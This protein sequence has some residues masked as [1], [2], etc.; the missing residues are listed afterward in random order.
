[1]N[2]IFEGQRS[3]KKSVSAGKSIKEYIGDPFKI[4]EDSYFYQ[5]SVCFTGTCKW[6][7]RDKLLQ[8]SADI[9]GFP[10]KGVNKSTCKFW[11]LVSKIT[12]ASVRM[13]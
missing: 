1:M 5:K 4:D 8:C 7:S 6:A 12:G 13:A 3:V 2:Y 10:P 11:L 9:G